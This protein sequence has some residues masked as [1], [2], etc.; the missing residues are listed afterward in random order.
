M[1]KIKG[2]ITAVSQSSGVSEKTGKPYTRYVFIINDK[3]YSSFD[4]GIGDNFKVGEL[5]EME[6]EQKGQFWNMKTMRALNPTDTKDELVEV[7]RPGAPNV[8]TMIVR[9][10]SLNR[11][12]EVCCN[13]P[14]CSKV[15]MVKA[16]TDMAEKFE[17]WVNR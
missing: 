2:I 17:A 7:I 12:T 9:Q 4:G 3:N 5:V 6:G 16:V 15:D 8:Q 1:E 11:A 10:S 13:I 14:E